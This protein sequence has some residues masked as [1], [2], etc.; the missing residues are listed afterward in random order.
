LLTPLVGA[1]N[2]TAEVQ[3]D[4][5]LDESQATRESYDKQG[6]VMRAEQGA[7]TGTSKDGQTPG[8]IPGALSN[9][10]PPA[11]RWSPECGRPPRR[12]ARRPA[13]TGLRLRRRRTQKAERQL[14]P[15]L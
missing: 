3:A 4:V 1:G 10:P 2:F 5:D 15:H 13:G 9:T 8:G 12:H 7:W 11:S 6:Q 14:H